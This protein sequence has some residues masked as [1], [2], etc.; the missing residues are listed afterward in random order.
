M[1]KTGSLIAAAA[2]LA[3][4][5]G[6]ASASPSTGGC[7]HGGP[8]IEFIDNVFGITPNCGSGGGGSVRAPEI[9]PASTIGAVSLLLGG[10]VVL[11]GR[12]AR[13]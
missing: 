13:A 9:D 3:L 10:L 4:S 2:L 6:I 7:G 12:K 11:R 5:S 1:S 8:I